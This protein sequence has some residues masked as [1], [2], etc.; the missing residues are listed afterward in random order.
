M[1]LEFAIE[2]RCALRARYAEDYLR[3]WGR[4]GNIHTRLTTGECAAPSEEKFRFVERA[5][6]EIERMREATTICEGCPARLP[7]ET[8]GEGENVGCLGR[9]TYP[10]EA[11]FEKFLADRVQI[12]LDTVDEADQPRL[13]RIL[14]DADSPFDG[15]GAKSLRAVTTADGL[16]FFDLRLPIKLTR[17]ASH[18]TTDHIYDALAGFTS[19]DSERTTYA[20]EL[21]VAAIADYYDFLDLILRNDISVSERERLH[22]RSRNYQQYLRLLAALELAET[23]HA[24]VLLD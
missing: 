17:E 23:L 11:Q 20:R 12:M 1:S 5:G 9:I 19:Q 14:V 7:Q 3:G 10:I 15:E 2:H 22:A 6:D 24:R 21:P 13:L 18:L 16:R 8:A 4:L